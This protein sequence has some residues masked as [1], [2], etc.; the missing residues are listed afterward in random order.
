MDEGFLYRWCNEL[1]AF[2]AGARGHEAAT[3][4][5]PIVVMII[6]IVIFLQ[7]SLTAPV[8]KPLK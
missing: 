1:V 3:V 6:I 4:S 7:T 5:P 2:A 8:I